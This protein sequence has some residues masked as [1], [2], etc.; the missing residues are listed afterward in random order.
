MLL[1]SQ[2]RQWLRSVG[3]SI[4]VCI[5]CYVIKY[6]LHCC[7]CELDYQVCSSKYTLP[8]A[9]RRIFRAPHP[10]AINSP[11]GSH[12]TDNGCVYAQVDWWFSLRVNN[13]SAHFYSLREIF[14]SAAALNLL[15]LRG[16]I[17]FSR[18]SFNWNRDIRNDCGVG[19][20]CATDSTGR[21]YALVPEIPSVQVATPDVIWP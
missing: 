13:S 1:V 19:K 3:K 15:L 20:K 9:W 12:G 21:D 2:Y 4:H 17:I 7:I 18:W 10:D 6:R 8:L 11:H 16:V 5:R 14:H